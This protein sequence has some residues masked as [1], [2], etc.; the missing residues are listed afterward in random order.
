[1]SES[2][3]VTC[4]HC[5]RRAKL[6]SAAALGR[7]MPC[8]GCGEPF[9]L[10]ADGGGGDAGDP[11]GGPFSDD[12]FA[13]A[14][15]PPR[16]TARPTP[17]KKAGPAARRKKKSSG[18][19]VPV[20]AWVVGGVAAALLVC[21]GGLA[22]LLFPAIDAARTAARQAAERNDAR[23]AAA[24]VASS[25]PP[26]PVAAAT[27]EQAREL[28]KKVDMAM[29]AGNAPLMAS[30]LD[31]DALVDVAVAG[32]NLQENDLRQLKAGFASTRRQITASWVQAVAG[33]DARFLG[34]TEIDG[35]PAAVVRLLP[36]GGGLSYMAF[37]PTPAGQILDVYAFTTGERVS[38]S[39][40]R[41]FGA[42]LGGTDQERASLARMA[43]MTQAM[44][45]GDGR[46]ALNVYD[47]MPESL[48]E[49]RVVQSA[50]VQASSLLDDPAAYRAALEDFDRRFPNDPSMDL[51]KM[52]F[53]AEDPPRLIATLE[54]LDAAVGGDPHLRG[55][56]A[57]YL[58][59][60]G[61]VEDAQ[62]VA[63]E[64]AD[65]EPELLQVQVGLMAAG[66][67]A[68]DF[69]AAADAYRK[70]RDEHDRSFTE[71]AL[72]E[73]FPRGGEF[74]DSPAWSR[75]RAEPPLGFGR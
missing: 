48:K 5:G 55:L 63:R 61:R 42:G 25:T 35:R 38:A 64:A 67:A 14:A 69:D 52:D 34:V 50:R 18:G 31:A 33:G 1:M 62:R 17:A 74:V 46:A 16:R 30:L 8:R 19:G 41:L 37:F 47:S 60:E 27:E 73:S 24:E 51:L 4:P 15:A 10:K 12:D 40:R 9:K 66:I 53:Y 36:A 54:R 44:N 75:V 23:Q 57:E 22:A 13:P 71:E 7:T 70:V 59:A 72:R 29:S 11:F 39:M 6:K 56:L 58:A 26:P 65:E 32:M 43:E 49:T 2:V 28:G 68:G 3:S 45:R 21:G 20:W